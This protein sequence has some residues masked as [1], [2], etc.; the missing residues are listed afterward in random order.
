MT[1]LP[2]SPPFRLRARLLSPTADGGV[3][4]EYDGPVRQIEERMLADLGHNE[5]SALRDMLNRCRAGLA[6]EPAH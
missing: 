6:T 5:R 3:L 2:A 4:D 1:A